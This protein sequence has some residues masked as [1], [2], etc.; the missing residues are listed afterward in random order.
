[1]FHFGDTMTSKPAKGSSR[2]NAFM[3]RKGPIKVNESSSSDDEEDDKYKFSFI[4]SEKIKEHQK[5]KSKIFRNA[6]FCKDA[7]SES[8]TI[9]QNMNHKVNETDVQLLSKKELD[10]YLALEKKVNV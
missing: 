7:Y 9:K 4:P 2:R 10:L 8:L 6:K 3:N 1:M 5:Q